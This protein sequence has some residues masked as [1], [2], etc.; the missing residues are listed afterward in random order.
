MLEECS[1]ETEEV[2]ERREADWDGQSQSV[3]ETTGRVILRKE[4]VV[5]DLWELS[6]TPGRDAYGWGLE[7]ISPRGRTGLCLTGVE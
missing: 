5:R 3:M 2:P 7:A 6:A 4:G 1:Q